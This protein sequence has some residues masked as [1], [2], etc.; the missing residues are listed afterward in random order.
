MV[1]LSSKRVEQILHEKTP[2]T[3]SLDT[4]LRLRYGKTGCFLFYPCLLCI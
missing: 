3:E 2:K 4:I 1:E